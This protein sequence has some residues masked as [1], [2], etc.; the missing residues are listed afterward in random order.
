[1]PRSL[2]VIQGRSWSRGLLLV[3]TDAVGRP[4]R[5]STQHLAAIEA[6]RRAG[7]GH[8]VFTSIARA[9]DSP[10]VLAP[11]FLATEQALAASGMSYTS[12][13][14]NLYAGTLFQLF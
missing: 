2:V 4:G 5:R 14:L 8:V 6:A 12:L 10:L 9:Y 1:M 7:V 13:R 3:S 11:E